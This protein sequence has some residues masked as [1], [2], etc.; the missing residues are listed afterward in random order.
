MIYLDNAATTFK[1]PQSVSRAVFGSMVNFGAN[2]GRGGYQ[3]SAKAGEIVYNTRELLCQFFGAGDESRIAFFPNTTYA[4]NSAIYGVMKNG[5]HVVTTSM[6]HNS[7]LRPLAELEKSGRVRFTVV[8]GDGYGR[9]SVRDL[10]KAI[11]ADTRLLVMTG[12]S[13]VCGNVYDIERAAEMAHSKGVL[14]LID[15]AQI[16]GMIPI[17]AQKFDLL[18]FPGHKGLMGPQGSGGLY[19][20]PH[21]ML[22]PLISGGTGSL[23]ES[24]Y[25]PEEM[26]DRLE[27][28]TLNMPAIA[29]LYEGVK[30]I[31]KE[32]VEAIHAREQMLMWYALESLKNMDNVECYGDFNDENRV[33]VLSFNIKG[34][35]S[36]AVANELDERFSIAVRGGLHCAAAAH[37]TLGTLSG[38]TV[39]MSFGYFNTKSEVKSAVEAIYKI[40]KEM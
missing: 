1:K 7:V 10:E 40:S 25:Q 28:G 16:A 35:D 23:S 27:S 34:A 14:V 20:A 19:V 22:S 12:A 8:K 9:I 39:R 2:A 29:G 33:G 30:F 6:E 18:A 32:S 3:L 4:L 17:N 36:V 31:M 11:R 24:M 5:G 38:G 13:N 26:P 37:K 15:A 21:V